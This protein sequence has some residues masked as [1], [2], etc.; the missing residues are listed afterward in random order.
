MTLLGALLSPHAW[1]ASIL[2]ILITAAFT[3]AILPILRRP[4]FPRSAPFVSKHSLP[5]IGSLGFFTQRAAFLT[6]GG[7]ASPTGQFSFNYGPHPIISLSGEAARTTFYTARGLDLGAGFRQLFAGGPDTS[8]LYEGDLI[9]F[10]A[11]NFRR[12]LARDRLSAN[13]KLLTGDTHRA[14]TPIRAEADSHGFAVIDIFEDFFRLV[15]QLT[16]RTLGCNDIANDPKRLASTLTAYKNL[17]VGSATEIMFPWLPTTTKVKKLWAGYSLFSQ[18]SAI[19]RER[20][21]T[22]RTETDVMQVMIDRGD[23]ESVITTV[24]FHGSMSNPQG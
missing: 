11:Q 5:L 3:L 24:C 10:F 8:H 4:A 23:D 2:V 13:L 14:I 16:H 12:F 22:G 21:K 18:I 15:Y 9:A 20:R 17:D 1:P 6:K 7:K 19:V